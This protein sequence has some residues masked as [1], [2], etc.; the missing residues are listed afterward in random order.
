ME[1]GYINNIYKLLIC[2][3]TLFRGTVIVPWHILTDKPVDPLY[4]KAKIYDIA[5]LK[6][7]KSTLPVIRVEK[8]KLEYILHIINLC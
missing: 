3:S 2:S 1:T 4:P 7:S 6:I 8:D 5:Q